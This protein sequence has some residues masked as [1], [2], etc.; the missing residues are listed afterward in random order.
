MVRVGEAAP[1]FELPGVPRG[2]YGLADYAGR[3]VVLV[4]YPGDA[5]PVCTMQLTS[6]NEQLRAFDEL[7]AQVLA[8]SPQGVESHERFAADHGFGFPL[9]ADKDKAVGRLYGII[10]PLGVY[11]RSVFVLDGHGI[12]RYA[13][14]SLWG[15]T[16]RPT[17]AQHDTGARV[18]YAY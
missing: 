15:A 17:G 11:R 7:G 1:R 2:R 8:I 13:H 9:L 10:G 4:F 3:P 6:Y 5:T 12:V 16:F 14:R 18:V